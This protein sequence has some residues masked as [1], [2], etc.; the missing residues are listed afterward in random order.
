MKRVLLVCLTTLISI[1]TWA[2]NFVEDDIYYNKLTDSTVEVTYKST[3]YKSYTMDE[4]IIPE[5]VIHEGIEYTVT[6]IGYEAF[7]S[8]TFSSISMP[9]T[10]TSIGQY[11]FWE[12]DNITELAIPNSVT[13]MGTNT[14]Y[15]CASLQKVIIGDGLETLSSGAFQNCAKLTDVTFGKAMKVISSNA[16][17]GCESLEEITFPE[18]ITE[19]AGSAFSTCINLFNITSLNPE[20]PTCQYATFYSSLYTS[21]TLYVPAGTKEAYEAATGWEN[22]KNIEEIADETT[23]SFEISSAGYATYY[24]EEAYVMPEG[25]TGTTVTGFNTSSSSDAEYVLTMPWE[26]E[27]G[28]TV[29]AGTALVLQGKEGTYEYD[30]TTSEEV[31]PTDNL[32]MGSTTAVETYGPDETGSYL[33]YELSYGQYGVGF[34]YGTTD[35][36]AFTSEANKAWLPLSE[37][38]ARGARFLG[39]GDGDDTTGISSVESAS[40]KAVSGIY[41]L[42]GVRVNDM[43]Q[44]GVYIVDGKKV[45]VK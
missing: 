42:Q 23:G 26:Y 13:S 8:S 27:A 22:F 35:G 17:S 29:P 24:I 32:L 31:A 2:Y 41:T 20:P 36:A 38:Q 45:L 43:N 28:S 15:K 5:T 7:D 30:I 39:F 9:E 4:L 19:I 18:T 12:V 40:E 11:A 34:Y 33:Y 6:A 1:V 10:I 37:S 25:V 3:S 44:K 16:F 21:A 14:F